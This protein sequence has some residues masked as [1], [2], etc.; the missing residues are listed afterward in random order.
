MEFEVVDKVVLKISPMKGITQFRKREK[1]NP[2]FIGPYEFLER[3]RKV[4]Y[5]LALPLVM[6][7]VH[8]IL[9]VLMLRKYV[10]D[11]THILQYLEVDY[12]PDIKEEIRPAKILDAKDK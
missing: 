10:S 11:P 6:F 9:Y 12:T 1:L 2:H 7:R 4:S 3:V 5:Q 8:N